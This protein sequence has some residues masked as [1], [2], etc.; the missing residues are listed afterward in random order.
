MKEQITFKLVYRFEN[1]MGR[2]IDFCRL[3][4]KSGLYQYLTKKGQVVET[5][6]F[7]DN[8]AKRVMKW[9]LS[10]NENIDGSKRTRCFIEKSYYLKE[11][12]EKIKDL[13]DQA[14]NR[15]IRL[16]HEFIKRHPDV[17]V[18]DSTG[19]NINKNTGANPLFELIEESMIEKNSVERNK[20]KAEGQRIITELTEY[21]QKLK[22][23]T[24]S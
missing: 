4:K 19:Q 10:Q 16:G 14:N 23:A 24:D 9:A 5:S 12:E 15:A 2:V 13:D 17:I 1:Q 18:K 7:T 11:D 6:E 21:I 8:D 3:D 22:E 20:K